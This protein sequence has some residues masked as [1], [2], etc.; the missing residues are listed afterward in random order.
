MEDAAALLARQSPHL[1]CELALHRTQEGIELALPCVLG[2]DAAAQL[3]VH[4]RERVTGVAQRVRDGLVGVGL[5]AELRLGDLAV[6][7][8]EAR[9]G[10]NL[11]LLVH[12]RPETLDRVRNMHRS[13]PVSVRKSFHIQ[14]VSTLGLRS[15]G[16]AEHRYLTLRCHGG[17]KGLGQRGNAYVS[18][19]LPDQHVITCDL[20]SL[21]HDLGQGTWFC[22]V[23]LRLLC[24]DAHGEQRESEQW[25]DMPHHITPRSSGTL[26]LESGQIGIEQLYA[27]FFATPSQ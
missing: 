11:R 20:F 8:I 9:C 25:E 1:Q 22:T 21:D 24:G 5:S 6:H 10:N 12:E 23:R 3:V 4:N 15:G 27:K 7:F 14:F 2:W 17:A 18:G 13:F 26:A 16:N 19:P